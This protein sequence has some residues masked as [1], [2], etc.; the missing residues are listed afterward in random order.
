MNRRHPLRKT[1]AGLGYGVN[2]GMKQQALAFLW[3]AG[4]QG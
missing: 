2:L 1:F 4:G 3:L